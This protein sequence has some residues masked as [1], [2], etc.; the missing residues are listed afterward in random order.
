MCGMDAWNGHDSCLMADRTALCVE[1]LGQLVGQF[2]HDLNNLLATALVGV[3]LAAQSDGD[4]R[5]Q[6]L[7]AS[8]IEAIQRQQALTTAM[9]RAAQSCEHAASVDAHALIEACSDEMRVVLGVATLEL[10]LDAANSRIRC[11][12][13]FFRVAL[14]HMAAN[15]RASMPNGGRLLLATRNRTP[16][17]TGA[18]Q[19]LLSAV[20]SGSGMSE[21]VRRQAFDVFFS[22]RGGAGLG[23]AQV[24]DTVRRSGGS[25]VLDTVPGQ[26]TA[27]TL[28]LPLS[29]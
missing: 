1:T 17:G 7:L 22:T 28:V 29:G 14:L 8:V 9:A 10:Q 6:E 19:L 26:G 13:G 18:G 11:D 3:E 23:L 5:V 25:V 20:D 12:P 2:A 27:I 21:D 15:A 24:R 16:P 4:A